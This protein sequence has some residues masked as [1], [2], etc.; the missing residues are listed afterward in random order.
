MMKNWNTIVSIVSFF[1]D[2]RPIFPGAT[3][4]LAK[5]SFWKPMGF[6]GDSSLH[7]NESPI[8]HTKRPPWLKPKSAPHRWDIIQPL[9]CR[10]FCTLDFLAAL[11]IQILIYIRVNY[12]GGFHVVQR[13]GAF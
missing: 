6:H 10:I 11:D 2:A 12:W 5:L 9:M 13:F 8:S 3:E 7:L 4:K 1:G